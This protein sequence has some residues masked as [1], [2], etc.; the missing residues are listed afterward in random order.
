VV[1]RAAILSCHTC[2]AMLQM[3]AV[4]QHGP[5]QSGLRFSMSHAGEA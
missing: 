5:E 2:F 1:K 3:L 4:A